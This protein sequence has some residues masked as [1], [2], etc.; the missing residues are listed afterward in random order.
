MTV[1]QK[2][3]IDEWWMMAESKENTESKHGWMMD[4]GWWK[5][6]QKYRKYK[7]YTLMDD[8]WKYIKHRITQFD[9]TF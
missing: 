7:N 2:V 6:L 3:Y 8:G 1:L 4:N 5:K 9:E